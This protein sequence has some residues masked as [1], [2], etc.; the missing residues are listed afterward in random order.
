MLMVVMATYLV[1]PVDIIPLELVG[2][3]DD[4]IIVAF[5]LLYLTT[6]YRSVAIARWH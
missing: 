2:F 4:L 5:G 6:L 1:S 3:V